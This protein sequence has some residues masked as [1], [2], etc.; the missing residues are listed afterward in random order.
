M[1]KRFSNLIF[2]SLIA[3]ASFAPEATYAQDPNPV[4]PN[5]LSLDLPD[6]LPEAS[7]NLPNQGFKAAGVPYENKRLGSLVLGNYTFPSTPEKAYFIEDSK[8]AARVRLDLIREAQKEILIS[9]HTLA[10]DQLGVRLLGELSAAAKRGVKVKLI[11]DAWEKKKNF[12]P[13]MKAALEA[14]G[15]EVHMFRPLTAGYLYNINRRM[16]DKLFIV[17]RKFLVQGDRN[18]TKDYYSLGEEAFV[19]KEFYF[20]GKVAK[21][22]AKY[23]DAL[24]EEDAVE[25]TVFNGTITDAIKEKMLVLD[26][27]AKKSKTNILQGTENWR[28]KLQQLDEVNFFHDNVKMKG[29]VSGTEAPLIDMIK[30]AKKRIIIENPYI[31]LTDEF[32]AALRIAHKN[33]VQITVI[34]NS[35]QATDQKLVGAA[36]EESR[37]FLKTMNATIWEHPGANPKN[38]YSKWKMRTTKNLYSEKAIHTKMLIV[39]DVLAVKSFNLDPRSQ[40]HNLEIVVQIKSKDMAEKAVKLVRT[41]ITNRNYINSVLH[42]KSNKLVPAVNCRTNKVLSYL[43]RYYL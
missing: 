20:E 29:K 34:T 4:D 36:W 42:G 22:S 43:L 27:N 40:N 35:P 32:R 16:H 15:V 24:I 28:N 13:A 10:E 19:S 8:V 17:D 31:V 1:R 9:T 26:R 21:T 3:L 11:V 6:G 25:R 38:D 18:L 30:N 5:Q 14:N 37:E 7:S 33:G 41:D 39:D 23:F 12:T 2:S